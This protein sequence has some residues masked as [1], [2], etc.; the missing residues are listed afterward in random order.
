MSLP[1]SPVVLLPLAGIHKL[2]GASDMNL[3]ALPGRGSAPGK[4]KMPLGQ[5]GTVQEDRVGC[6]SGPDSFRGRTRMGSLIWHETREKV[7]AD[8]LHRTTV[9]LLW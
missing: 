1:G 7:P 5:M 9:G 8:W 6:C 4:W 3:D 2:R